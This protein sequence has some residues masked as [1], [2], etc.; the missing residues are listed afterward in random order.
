VVHSYKIERLT[1]LVEELAG[2]PLMVAYQFEHEYE[3]LIKAFPDALAIKGGMSKG[4]LQEVVESWNTGNVSLLFVQPTAAALG[5]NLQFGGSAICWFSMTYNLEE[6]IQLIARLL[7]RG[8]TK[9]V[10]NYKLTAKGTI[11]EVLVK[12][13]GNKDATQNSVFEEL[14]R[15][16]VKV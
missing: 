8:Q 9:P 5:L 6:Y 16:A 4:K 12:I 2:E 1:S 7:R 15:L 11:D 13:M 14:K 3:R 10:M